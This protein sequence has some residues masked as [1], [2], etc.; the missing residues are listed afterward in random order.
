MTEGHDRLLVRFNE[1]DYLP[2]KM[3][4]INY[5]NEDHFSVTWS[6][7]DDVKIESKFDTTRVLDPDKW[8]IEVRETNNFVKVSIDN[9]FW[10]IEKW[11]RDKNEVLIKYGRSMKNFLDVKVDYGRP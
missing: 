11:I 7:A 3:A 1:K 6:A 2:A 8:N 4:R 5:E 10:V 9:K